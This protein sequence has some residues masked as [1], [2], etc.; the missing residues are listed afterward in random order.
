MMACPSSRSRSRRLRVLPP[1]SGEELL[2][3][4]SVFSRFPVLLLL[5]EQALRPIK[6]EEADSIQLSDPRV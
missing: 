1:V 6:K 5:R 4:G 3:E 2:L